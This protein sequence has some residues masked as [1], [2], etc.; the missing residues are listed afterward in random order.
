MQPAGSPTAQDYYRQALGDMKAGNAAAALENYNKALALNPDYLEAIVNRGNLLDGMGRHAEALEACRRA[1][2]L[3][4]DMPELL[5]NEGNILRTM[6][7][8]TEALQSYNK[9]LAQRPKMLEALVNRST[10]FY[11]LRRMDEALADCDAVLAQ[12]PN[13]A[14]VH[15]NRANMLR[16]KGSHPEALAAATRAAELKPG[17]AEAH[18]TRGSL[19]RLM[20]R[21]EEA[22]DAFRAAMEANPDAPMAQGLYLHAKMVLCDWADYG[23]LAARLSGGLRAGKPV[24]SPFPYLAM[25]STPQEQLTCARLYVARQHPPQAPLWKG[26]KYKNAKIR[27]AY[28]SADFHGHATAYLMAGLFEAHDRSRF[29]IRAYSFGKPEKSAMRSRLE[30]SFSAFI[31]VQKHDDGAIARM[32]LENETDIAIDLKGFT[33]EARAGIFARR[34]APVQVNYIG[35]PGTMGAPYID[36]IIADSHLIA[37]GDETAYSE[38]IVR[39]PDTYQPNDRKRAIA[40]ETPSRASQGL[41]EKAFVFCCFNNSYKITPDIFAVWM[42]LLKQVEGSVLWLLDSGEA[43]KTNLKREAAAQGID[44]GRLVF[45]PRLPPPRHLARHRAADLF[46]DTLPYNAHTTASDALW[47]GLPLVTC[48]GGTFAARVAA[49]LLAAAGLPEMITTTLADYEALALSLA[50]NPQ[51]LQAIK[52]KLAKNRDSCALFDTVRYARKLESAF[53]KM[54]LRGRQGLPPEHLDIE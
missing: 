45:A 36:Y 20:R 28:L 25:P 34:P 3:R 23:A 53:E 49:S 48:K 9:A 41:P 40:N 4:P 22:R 24:T 15:L 42:R 12:V 6:K 1:I 47:A 38:K 13:F 21:K 50:K 33:Q 26:E 5:A 17:Y 2:S 54:A 16:E 39:L 19:L 51:K 27:I 10:L 35:Y 44:A 8:E 30:Q 14:E 46:L 11:D 32:L 43:V 29:D 37:A 52:E 31:D 18:A 7:R